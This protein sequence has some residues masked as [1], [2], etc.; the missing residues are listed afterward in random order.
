LSSNCILFKQQESE[1]I[2]GKVL[3][4][5]PLLGGRGFIVSLKLNN[6][7]RLDVNN[8]IMYLINSN[9]CIAKGENK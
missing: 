7:M 4:P 9:G 2:E 5:L 6:R 3:N 8:D 1:N